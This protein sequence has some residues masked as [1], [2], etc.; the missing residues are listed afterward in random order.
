LHYENERCG[1]PEKTPGP[2]T[3]LFL[4]DTERLELWRGLPVKIGKSC[5]NGVKPNWVDHV[6]GL[7][8]FALPSSF[9]T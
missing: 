5:W 9:L 8:E 6:L 7:D 3:G 4:V 1:K 2:H